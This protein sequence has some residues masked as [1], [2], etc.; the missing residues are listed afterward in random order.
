MVEKFGLP[1]SGN[2]VRK[3]IEG[4]VVEQK[5]VAEQNARETAEK[6]WNE[7]PGMHGT[8]KHTYFGELSDGSRSFA[9]A[10][11]HIDGSWF[12]NQEELD[13]EIEELEKDPFTQNVEWE[14]DK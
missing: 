13:K 5:E 14:E 3:E 8:L 12:K 11:T 6:E 9:T 7:R 1:A 4:G 2:E 10:T